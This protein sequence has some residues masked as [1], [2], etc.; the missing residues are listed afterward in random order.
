MKIS[1]FHIRNHKKLDHYLYKLCKELMFA[2]KE[3][4]ET[5]GWV[6][7]GILDPRNRFIW[8]INVP[9]KED[10]GDRIHAERAAVAKYNETYGDIPEGSIILTTL[11]PCSE[12]MHDREGDSCTDLINH[13]PL[14]KVY[15]GFIDPTQDHSHKKFT[16]ECTK[17]EKI[18]D[19]CKSFAEEFLGDLNEDSTTAEKPVT[20]HTNPYYRGATIGAGV[21]EQLP[22]TKMPIDQLQMWEGDKNLRTKKVRDWVK[23]TLI[24]KLQDKG[25]LKPMIVWNRKGKHFVIDGNHRFLA[26]KAAGYKGDVPVKVVPNNIVTVNNK[27]LGP[28][29]ENFADGKGPGRAGDSQRHGIPKGAT[30]AQLEKASHAKGRKGQLARWQLNMRRGKEK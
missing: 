2:K 11:S 4:P 18:I 8:A 16:L 5:Y 28:V 17:N 12:Y 13:S 14:R 15:C 24:P 30:I 25:Q 20:I 22:V 7:A 26:Y 29:D 9:A 21:K 10:N 19:I 1:D 6:A 23:N 27:V 3:D